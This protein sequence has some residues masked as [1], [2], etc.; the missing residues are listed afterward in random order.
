MGGNGCRRQ[1][2][3]IGRGMRPGRRCFHFVGPTGSTFPCRIRLFSQDLNLVGFPR[4]THVAPVP[5]S[6]SLSDLSTV[7]VSRSCCHFAVRRDLRRSNIRVTGVRDLV[8]LGDGTFLSLDRE[9]AGNRDISDGRVTGRGGSIFHLTT[10]LAPTDECRLPGA[11]G[12][13]IYSFYSTVVRSL[14]GTSF[15]GSTNLN[16]IADLRV[17]RRLGGSVL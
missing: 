1:G 6:R 11:L 8:Y 17:V 5:I 14:P 10:V 12:A 3:N 13:S 16:G 15:V 4:R 7:L 2:G 9:G